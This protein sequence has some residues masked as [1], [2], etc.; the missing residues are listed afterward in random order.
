MPI[1]AADAMHNAA[2]DTDY[3]VIDET[4]RKSWLFDQMTW[5][6]TATP[7]TGGGSLTYT[8]GRL[9]QTRGGA[10][11]AYNTEY[12]PD[13]A[14]RTQ[15]T[16]S[17]YPFGGAYN[18]DRALAHLGPRRYDEMAFQTTEMITG[19]LVTFSD[20]LVNGDHASD[21]LGF[22][23]LDV[24]LTGSVTEFFPN[25]TTF[26]ADWSAATLDTV[27]EAITASDLLDE[28]LTLLDGEADALMG[29]RLLLNRV[30]ALAKRAGQY[31]IEPDSLGRTIERYGN[32]VLVDLGTVNSDFTGNSYVVPVET[33]D[34]DGAGGGGNITNLTD[35][36]AVRFGL[37]GLHGATMAG[38]PLMQSWDPDW[39]SSGAV[40]T[41]EL[42]IGPATLVLKK[43]RSC[44]V[45]RN[46]K[47]K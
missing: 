20:K 37:Q 35:L 3:A 6:D 23:G 36:Y 14:K 43:S 18:L 41:G 7:G 19:A 12:T 26:Y 2:S 45:F 39:F 9:T 13:Q 24:A 40:K 16:N 5:D 22:D 27:D 10:F 25:A 29:N 21:P 1:T 47:V 44:G 33:R 46:I 31:T 11:R 17:L 38:K 4:R 8:Y 28:F 34:P 15:I 32:A 30:K 42:E